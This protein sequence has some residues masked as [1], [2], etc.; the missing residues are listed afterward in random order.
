MYYLKV[1]LL[2]GCPYC[3]KTKNILDKY[4]FKKNIITVYNQDKEKW[5]S[6]KINTF[7]QIYLMRANKKNHLLLGGYNDLNFIE[8]Q[9]S[10]LNDKNLNDI[11]ENITSK[12]N[13]ISN[14][15]TL[16]LIELFI[17]NQ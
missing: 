7:P 3:K 9:I 10:K 14:K 15:S 12:Y 16:R 8:N 11:K 4:K 2:D 17:K 1:I 13:H 5:K 6:R